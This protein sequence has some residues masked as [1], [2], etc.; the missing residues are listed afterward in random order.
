MLGVQS[1]ASPIVHD[2]NSLLVTEAGVEEGV[3]ECDACFGSLAGSGLTPG[4]RKRFQCLFHS[5]DCLGVEWTEDSKLRKQQ[6]SKV[7]GGLT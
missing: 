5:V 7:P 2:I 3:Q 6:R 4:T 1:E